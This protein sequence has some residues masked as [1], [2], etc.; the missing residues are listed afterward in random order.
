MADSSIIDNLLLRKAKENYRAIV[1][2]LRQQIIRLLHDNARMPVT[3][4]YRK[5]KLEQS[6]ASQQLA[7]LRKAGLV[8][9]EREGKQIFYS[10]NYQRLKLLHKVAEMLNEKKVLLKS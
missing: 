6:V 1:H 2:P 8:L 10:V 3:S 7:I 9:A 4:I 5:L